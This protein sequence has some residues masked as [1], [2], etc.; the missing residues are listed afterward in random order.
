MACGC[1][2]PSERHHAAGGAPALHSTK[3]DWHGR[4]PVLSKTCPL[5]LLLLCAV[6]FSHLHAD[7]I[8]FQEKPWAAL[9]NQEVSANGQTALA[10]RPGAW[11][12]GES[13]HF[14]IHY[15]RITEAKRVALEIEFH[16]AY[17]AKNLGA[18]P[19]RYARK[20]HVFIFEDERDWKTFIAQTTIPPWT[21]SFAYG[22]ELF[23]NVR[24][25]NT[26]TFDSQTL[27]HETTHAVVARL[28][29]GKRWPLWL[30]EGF[31]EQMSG[32]SVG[33]RMGQYNP[34]LLQ[35][36]QVATV[37]LDLLTSMTVYPPD[38]LQVAALYQSAEKLVR[39]LMVNNPPERF[40][41]LIDALLDDEDL[42]AAV[43]KIYPDR[44][45]TYAAFQQ[46]YA[47]LPR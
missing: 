42:A 5:C 17:V 24:N 32:Q 20:S 7:E 25:G 10:V 47:R 30:S 14:I 44:Y 26:G 43:P 15:R 13:P 37:P 9:A 4:I 28:Y 18:G 23:L 11:L 34:R 38:T 39:F 41:K 12:H 1:K 35:R 36:F 27:A 33:A 31:A 19:E 46:A 22:D 3:R 8:P 21:A 29:P 45:P 16:L 2:A 40:T 6:A